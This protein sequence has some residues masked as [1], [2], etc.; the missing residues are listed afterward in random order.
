M[1]HLLQFDAAGATADLDE[2]ASGVG[3]DPTGRLAQTLLLMGGVDLVSG[4]EAWR[5]Y[6]EKAARGAADDGD[7]GLEMD[8]AILQ[9]YAHYF[10]GERS[11]GTRVCQIS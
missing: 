3:P 11:Q 1:I 2:L 6:L 4:G 7:V 5:D 10:W 9:T 8:V